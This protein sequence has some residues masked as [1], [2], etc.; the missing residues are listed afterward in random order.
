MNSIKLKLKACSKILTKT[1][2]DKFIMI[3]PSLKKRV[4]KKKISTKEF[5]KEFSK[6]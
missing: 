4:R 2:K 5:I 1:H 6:L 3:N